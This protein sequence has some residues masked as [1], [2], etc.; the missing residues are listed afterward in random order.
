MYAVGCRWMVGNGL[1]DSAVQFVRFATGGSQL[2]L[3]CLVAIHSQNRQGRLHDAG[4]ARC[5]VAIFVKGE[6]GT[7]KQA[8]AY[9]GRHN[10]TD[11]QGAKVD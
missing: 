10:G 4:G 1:R 11:H 6:R 3:C 5:S 8:C 9:E 7:I 2:S